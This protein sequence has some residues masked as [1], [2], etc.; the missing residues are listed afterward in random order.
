MLENWERQRR[1][2]EEQER[3]RLYYEG[4]E[5]LRR[6]MEEDLRRKQEQQDRERED[7]LR[8]GESMIG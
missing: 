2:M 4:L 1:S 7:R 5:R 6:P 3:R 8:R